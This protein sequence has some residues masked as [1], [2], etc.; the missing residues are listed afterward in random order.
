MTEQLAE[1]IEGFPAIPV[2]DLRVHDRILIAQPGRTPAAWFS[3]VEEIHRHSDAYLIKAFGSDAFASTGGRH[4]SIK[5]RPGEPQMGALC[6][7]FGADRLPGE[8]GFAFAS[9]EKERIDRGE[10]AGA[11]AA[12]EAGIQMGLAMAAADRLLDPEILDG[13]PLA[14]ALISE[15]ARVA[16]LPKHPPIEDRR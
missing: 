3:R 10:P 7:G 9:W 8:D 13:A 1:P 14:D 15:G 5:Q 11:A 4:V 2:R 16:D 6:R 12:F